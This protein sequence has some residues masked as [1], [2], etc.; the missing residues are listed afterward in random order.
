M[1]LVFG[2]TLTDGTKTIGGDEKYANKTADMPENLTKIEVCLM[3]NEYNLHHIVF[4]GSTTVYMGKTKE[5]D[6]GWNKYWPG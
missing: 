6:K 1:M 4:I 2:M 5:D 3:K